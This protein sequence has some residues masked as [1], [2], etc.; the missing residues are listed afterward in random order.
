MRQ[1]EKN[2]G[3]PPGGHS[4]HSSREGESKLLLAPTNLF[5]MHILG[6]ALP[7]LRL[8]LGMSLPKAMVICT[9]MFTAASFV[10]GNNSNAIQ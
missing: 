8:L 3:V 2:W 5:G 4:T 7:L 10:V 1:K 6:A 9:R